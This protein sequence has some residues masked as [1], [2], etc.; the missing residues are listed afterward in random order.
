MNSIRGLGVSLLLL[1]VS[2]EPYQPTRL[3]KKSQ[4]QIEQVFQLLSSSVEI[5]SPM[6]LGDV[7]PPELNRFNQHSD[8]YW[9]PWH[10]QH[11]AVAL[12]FFWNS[13]DPQGGHDPLFRYVRF[14]RRLAGSDE[15]RARISCQAM[16]EHAAW[17]EPGHRIDFIVPGSF[18]TDSEYFYK[19]CPESVVNNATFLVVDYEALHGDIGLRVSKDY[20]IPYFA[21]HAGHIVHPEVH[22]ERSIL[23]FFC[24]SPYG[25]VRAKFWEKFERDV[26]DEADVLISLNKITSE[27]YLEKLA[28]STFCLQLPGHTVSSSRLYMAIKAGCIPVFISDLYFRVLPYKDLFDWTQISILFPD[29]EAHPQ[30]VINSLRRV[31][32]DEI[33]RLRRNLIEAEKHLMAFSLDPINPVTLLFATMLL[34]RVDSCFYDQIVTGKSMLRANKE[35]RK[36]CK[37]LE[38]RIQEFIKDDVIAGAK[39]LLSDANG[40][41][42]RYSNRSHY[43][44][45]CWVEKER[46]C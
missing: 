25:W 33:L 40:G 28:N 37:L 18:K 42:I 43:I 1:R 45:Y 15:A 2:G 3:L 6:A 13:S 44:P 19:F 35:P 41:L 17:A 5:I 24:S 21:D 31:S 32:R 11:D 9:I 4:S 12:R 23:I 46:I 27:V 36:S 26:R 10:F 7:P 16:M 14:D 34:E 8:E 29:A 30:D 38:K 20:V 22:A 39:E